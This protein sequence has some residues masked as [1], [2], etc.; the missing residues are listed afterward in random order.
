[1]FPENISS[2]E[3][4][5][6]FLSFFCWVEEQAAKGGRL[7]TA[8]FYLEYVRDVIRTGEGEISDVERIM[9]RVYAESWIRT[10]NTRVEDITYMLDQEI[11]ILKGAG[12]L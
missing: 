7:I 2:L 4:A 10:S 8:P 11:K 5:Y 12:L 3:W 6:R 9:G 1:M